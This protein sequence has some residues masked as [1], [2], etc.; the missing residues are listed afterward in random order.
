MGIPT[1]STQH[2]FPAGIQGEHFMASAMAA[3]GLS[4]KPLTLAHTLLTKTTCLMDPI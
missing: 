2:Y 1:I 3:F 4:L